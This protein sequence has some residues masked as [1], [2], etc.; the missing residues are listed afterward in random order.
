MIQQEEIIT[1][2]LFVETN[3]KFINVHTI[4]KNAHLNVEMVL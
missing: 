1:V 2:R 3:S 4:N